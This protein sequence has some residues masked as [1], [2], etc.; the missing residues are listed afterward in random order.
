M[1]RL[2]W[3]PLYADKASMEIRKYLPWGRVPVCQAVHIQPKQAALLQGECKLRQYTTDQ[4]RSLESRKTEQDHVHAQ[5]WS[6]MVTGYGQVFCRYGQKEI[7][8]K[9]ITK[10]G[11]T[12]C[13]F[14]FIKR[15]CWFLMSQSLEDLDGAEWLERKAGN[16]LWQT[17]PSNLTPLL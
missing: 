2:C 10:T 6:Q 14:Y 13:D 7:L 5:C 3:H 1:T 8:W 12:K 16:F 4:C 11:L 15:I 9:L 17:H